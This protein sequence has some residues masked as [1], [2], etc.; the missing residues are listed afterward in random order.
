MAQREVSVSSAGRFA[1]ANL[2]RNPALVEALRGGADELGFR[3]LWRRSP[4][5]LPA[6][7]T[8]FR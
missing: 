8:S 7:A 3:W 1:E 2:D 6:V 4:G 5:W